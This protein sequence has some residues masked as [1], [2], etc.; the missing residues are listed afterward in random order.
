MDVLRGCVRL[1]A[2]PVLLSGSAIPL[3]GSRGSHQRIRRPHL[4]PKRLHSS[5]HVAIPLAE[6]A[7]QRL[8]LDR[9]QQPPGAQPRADPAV[10]AVRVP[11]QAEQL[12]R[13][14]QRARGEEVVRD[15]QGAHGRHGGVGA[16][17]RHPGDEDPERGGAGGVGGED[18]GLLRRGPRPGGVVLA[19][20]GVEEARDGGAAEEEDEELLGDFVAEN[21]AR[22]GAGVDVEDG[23][24]E[25][26]ESPLGLDEGE[27]AVE[28][29]L[30]ADAVGVGVLGAR[31]G[32]GV[33]VA[34]CEGLVAGIQVPRVFTGV[35]GCCRLEALALALLGGGGGGHPGNVL[36]HDIILPVDP[37]VHVGR[38]GSLFVGSVGLVLAGRVA[39][40]RHRVVDEEVVVAKR[41]RW[42]RGFR[43]GG[44][45][46]RG[47]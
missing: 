9:E 19:R 17:A 22:G 29:V 34:S 37:A 40:V 18:Q 39:R 1:T 21:G 38:N 5:I 42:R 44:S 32:V 13:L 35:V 27:E 30:V 11:P 47:V 2:F 45:Q 33:R 46:R 6:T 25:G 8:D 28:G 26:V 31:A 7:P 20:E 15:G 36:A 16:G 23:A 41:L 3:S 14:R 24:A 10:H 43:V 12:H 4:P